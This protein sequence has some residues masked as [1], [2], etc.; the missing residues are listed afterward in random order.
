MSK[1]KVNT[2]SDILTEE[3]LHNEF[4]KHSISKEKLDLFQD[5]TL[6]LIKLLHTT[7][8][9]KDCINTKEEIEGHYEWC[10]DNTLSK[11]KE[12]GIDFSKNKELKMYFY[13]GSEKYIYKNNKYNSE[14][15]LRTDT[16]YYN[17]IFNTTL[18][19]TQEDFIILLDLFTKFNRTFKV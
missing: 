2:M 15:E 1:V 10:Y 19:K 3:R 7:Y 9:G 11:F 17:K 5:F 8:L 18:P 6:Y 14:K 13:S 16:N 12:I 4:R